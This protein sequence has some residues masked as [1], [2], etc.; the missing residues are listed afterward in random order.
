MTQN[1]SNAL[2]LLGHSNGSLSM[3]TPRDPSHKPVVSMFTHKGPLKNIAVDPTG[4]YIAT[5]GVEGVVKI[6]DVRTYGCLGSVSGMEG[7]SSMQI[8]QKGMLAVGVRNQVQVYKHSTEIGNV[9]MRHTLPCTVRSLSFCPYEDTLAIG[10]AHGVSSILIPGSGEPSF[11]SR[12]PNP[13]S[14]DRFV[15]DWNVR[16][17]LDKLPSDSICLDDTI[18]GSSGRRAADYNYNSNVEVTE[19]LSSELKAIGVKQVTKKRKISSRDQLREELAS[20]DQQTKEAV[21]GDWWDRSDDALERFGSLKRRKTQNDQKKKMDTKDALDEADAQ[22]ATEDLKDKF[23]TVGA[24]LKELMGD[25]DKVI[26]VNKGRTVMQ[27]DTVDEES[28][29]EDDASSESD[30]DNAEEDNQEESDQEESDGI[31]DPFAAFD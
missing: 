10:H 25:D 16:S 6:W 3:C 31:V 14:D 30:D 15:K 9:Y 1:P 11:D 8:S 27:E 13:Y 28:D 22:E 5:A 20:R 21:G 7:L 19:E 12:T 29:D 2:I 23:E 18:I 24:S 26:R 17:L 4:T